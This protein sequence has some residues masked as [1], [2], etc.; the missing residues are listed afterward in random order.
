MGE[1]ATERQ[2]IMIHDLKDPS[3]P[4]GR[5]YRQINAERQHVI[6][7]GSLVEVVRDPEWPTGS[8]GIRLYVVHHGRDCDMTPLYWLGPDRAD[9]SQRDPRFANPKWIGG[10]S[11]ESLK[12]IDRATSH[13]DAGEE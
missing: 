6:Q 11:G 5:T 1:H 7:I 8:D 13:A 9:T 10:F 2:F 12:V 3:D 4:A